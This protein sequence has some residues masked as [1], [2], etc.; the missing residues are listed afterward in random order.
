[1]LFTTATR[2]VLQMPTY[3]IP[4]LLLETITPLKIYMAENPSMVVPITTFLLLI[5]FGIGLPATVGLSPQMAR[6]RV[7]EVEQKYQNLGYDELYYNK[8]L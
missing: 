4:P 2:A 6:I 5:S 8:G 3:F 1:M 7:E